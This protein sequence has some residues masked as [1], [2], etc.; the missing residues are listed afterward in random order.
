MKQPAF[1]LATVLA[2]SAAAQAPDEAAER[3]RIAAERSRMD[4]EFEA[5]HRACYSRFAVNDCIAAAKAKRREGLADLRR[6][7]VALN[8]AERRRR[9]AERLAEIEAREAE[10]VQ[11]QRPQPPA[12]QA[13]ADA[14][15]REKQPA[16]KAP[17][18]ERAPAAP[19]APSGKAPR[20][21]KVPEPVDTEENRRRYNQRMA[22]AAAHKA[23]VEKR[24]AEARKNVRP[25]PVPP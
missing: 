13:G 14:P 6:R 19:K 18:P 9:A 20:E 16:A 21:A 22:E 25:L 15:G 2:L 12:A 5:S 23:E 4:A 7:E 24:A 3:A 11:P 10:R 1:F 17:R 8:D